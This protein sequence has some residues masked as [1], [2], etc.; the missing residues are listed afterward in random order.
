[1]SGLGGHMPSGR[2]RGGGG[3]VDAMRTRSFGSPSAAGVVA[4]AKAEV[5]D[6]ESAM[7]G[8]SSRRPASD[9]SVHSRA[10]RIPRL[11]SSHAGEA[12]SP[13]PRRRLR[14]RPRSAG[15][16]RA[17]YD[18]ATYGGHESRARGL[19]HDRARFG[20]RRPTR[21]SASAL[22]GA[23]PAEFG[24]DDA[25]TRGS[26][27]GREDVSRRQRSFHR[28]RETYPATGRGDYSSFSVGAVPA[29]AS[30]QLSALPDLHAYGGG[31]SRSGERT[32]PRRRSR[33][34]SVSRSPSPDPLG[35]GGAS[36]ISSL[37]PLANARSTS[38]AAGGIGGL[39]ATPPPRRSS[40]DSAHHKI[41]SGGS[42]SGGIGIGSGARRH[43]T[44]GRERRRSHE[45]RSSDADSRS[46]VD[47][48]PSSI[49]EEAE[50]AAEGPTGAAPFVVEASVRAVSID[51]PPAGLSRLT[52]SG[53]S[54]PT[55]DSPNTLSSGSSTSRPPRPP[56]RDLL[57]TAEAGTTGEATDAAHTDELLAD[58]KSSDEGDDAAR[59]VAPAPS[60]PE[61]V[62]AAQDAAG[63]KGVSSTRAADVAVSAP[64]PAPARAANPFAVGG[65]RGSA[66]SAARVPGPVAPGA[67]GSGGPMP[68]A[69]FKFGLWNKFK[70][71][72]RATKPLAVAG[73]GPAAADAPTPFKNPF[74]RGASRTSVLTDES[75]HD[76]VASDAAR[77][78]RRGDGRGEPRL[79]KS[80]AVAAAARDLLI[81]PDAATTPPPRAPAAAANGVAHPRRSSP[82]T[83]DATDVGPTA[84]LVAAAES[85]LAAHAAAGAMQ[86]RGG[87]G[88]GKTP[89]PPPR[90]SPSPESKAEAAAD[91]EAAAAAAKEEPEKLLWQRGEPLGSGTFGT[92][93]TAFNQTTGALFAVK[94][95]KG[96]NASDARELQ[97]EIRVMRRL[98]HPHIVRYLGAEREAGGINIFMELV[99]GGSVAT[100]LKTYGALREPVVRRYTRQILLGVAYLHRRGV[101]HR[102]IKGGNVLVSDHGVAKLADFGCA[103]K[104]LGVVT[105]SL[106]DSLRKIRGSVPWMAPEVIRQTGGGRLADIWSIGATVIEMATAARPW[107]NLSNNLAAL[108]HVATSGRSPPIP[109]SLSED[110]RDFIMRCC[111]PDPSKRWSADKLLSHPFVNER[112]C[113]CGCEGPAVADDLVA[114]V[115]RLAGTFSLSVSMDSTRS[116]APSTPGQAGGGI[117]DA[118]ASSARSG[119]L[120]ASSAV[121]SGGLGVAD[122]ARASQ[123][124]RRMVLT[125][126]GP[127]H[128]TGGGSD[129]AS[130]GG[131]V[132][133]ATDTGGASSGRK[134]RVASAGPR[135]PP[136]L[137]PS[138]QRAG[139]AGRVR[140]Q[141]HERR[142]SPEGLSLLAAA[143]DGD[144]SGGRRAPSPPG[145]GVSPEDAA[146][147]AE[148]EAA[149]SD[150][151]AR[152]LELSDSSELD[153]SEGKENGVVV[154]GSGEVEVEV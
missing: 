52:A 1:M 3:G 84:G 109:D 114:E 117:D 53:L 19:D 123:H 21:R 13:E 146:D 65:A 24:D 108:F 102:D 2:A 76:D 149:G 131:G 63:T 122:P 130:S 68:A 92:V 73:G 75:G 39:L 88:A 45:R 127:L 152:M 36:P 140:P 143:G 58:S 113:H 137:P 23:L 12:A 69:A 104:L 5:E 82:S 87:A 145:V 147:A 7:A 144:G 57:D 4:A 148:A 61:S 96:D 133:G 154:G 112:L 81:Q 106:D 97:M 11:L 110:G 38:E 132:S 99:P 136:R 49:A 25:V 33:R 56:P 89:S 31:R 62:E 55:Q 66:P 64:T 90:E 125:T 42:R 20:F 93:Y 77:A 29:E 80:P 37:S 26:D 100:L 46:D 103:T 60:P 28:R 135:P 40:S 138:G 8:V 118:R 44:G 48:S 141:P 50:G 9:S 120:S 91:R 10:S 32:P 134:P 128:A 79:M 41:S 139:S 83:R 16:Q 22:D 150:L 43:R 115:A 27:Y 34:R 151:V 85:E 107:P 70:P 78:R 98:R 94:C 59:K 51:S 124:S 67:V 15:R 74:A 18:S 17:G 129:A 14:E 54:P 111:A 47:R 86:G 153:D 119:A 71:T 35:S 105:T 72:A 95:V 126:S 116:L 142:R 101:V 121:S 6:Y 30:A